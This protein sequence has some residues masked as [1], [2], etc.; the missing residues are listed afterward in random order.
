MGYLVA[1]LLG[2]GLVVD[3]DWV[4]FDEVA[5][6]VVLAFPLYLILFNCTLLYTTLYF[7]RD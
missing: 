3:T 1:G 6:A 5:A 7:P 2:L 4:E